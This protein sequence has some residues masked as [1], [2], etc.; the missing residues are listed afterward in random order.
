MHS[1][2]IESTL[3]KFNSVASLVLSILV[4]SRPLIAQELST[5]PSSLEFNQNNTGS[6]F[7]TSQLASQSVNGLQV[8]NTDHIVLQGESIELGN[9][10]QGR[11]S[12]RVV[13]RG[14]HLIMQFDG[15]LGR[16]ERKRLK[17]DGITVL[18][19]VSENNYWVCVDKNVDIASVRHVRWAA[20]PAAR[21]KMDKLVERSRFPAYAKYK[22]DAFGVRVLLFEGADANKTA[23]VIA[24]FNGVESVRTD[25]SNALSVR[26]S[27]LQMENIAGL[28][29]VKWLEPEAPP[30]IPFNAIAAER[31][32]AAALKASPYQLLGTG[33]S[34]GVWDGG[35]VDSH[36]DFGGRLTVVD[37]VGLNGHATHVAGTLAGSGAGYANAEGMAPEV[38]IY[39]YDW[40]DDD[41]EMRNAK[42]NRQ[43][44]I[45]NHSYGFSTGWNENQDGTWTDLGSSGFGRYDS[46]AAS[47]DDIVYDTGLHIFKA[48]GNERAHGPDCPAGP[49][50]DGPYDSIPYRG[51]AK[52]IYT[53][54]GTDDSDAMT[55]FS[56]W[57]PSNDGRIKPDLCANGAT[58]LS[59]YTGGQYA[60]S[61]GSSFASPSAA[62]T[63]ALLL[64]HFFASYSTEPSVA[65]LKTLMI[66]GAKD[67]GSDG[68][69]YQFGWGLIDAEKTAVLIDNKAFAQGLIASQSEIQQFQFNY[70]GGDLKVSLGWVDPA[71]STVASK[72]LVNDLDLELVAPGGAVYKPWVLNKDK[73][74]QAASTGTNN[75]DNTEQVLVSSA[76]AGSWTARVSASALP[77]GPQA[78]ALTG[79]GISPVNS[80]V[81]VVSN[82][83]E[84]N[85]NVSSIAPVTPAPWMSITP[86]GFS[87]SAGGSQIV[88]VLIDFTLAQEGT[89]STNLTISSNAGTDSFSV[90]VITPLSDTD[91][92]GLSDDIELLLGTKLNNTDSDDDGLSDYDEVN[93]DGDPSNYTIG[94]DLDPNDEDTDGDGIADGDDSEPLVATKFA[95]VPMLPTWAIF[96]VFFAVFVIHRK[97]QK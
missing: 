90:Q 9:L 72:A 29:N 53:I 18:S 46:Y 5:A 45:S 80:K 31:V 64:E 69:D 71:G 85:L 92:D 84:T 35:D 13:N 36:N 38:K 79:A 62:G 63:A 70:A 83:G 60:Q 52:N 42:I 14:R 61:S 95:V 12:D 28:E 27:L 94:I 91:G 49:D 20:K 21:H 41:S 1:R 55:S 4:L 68:P 26:G 16:G 51:N 59:T 93:R 24:G 7:S 30:V 32:K 54:C 39:S 40:N 10:L 48:A 11:R 25:G 44:L 73:P 76:A 88:R 2:L 81:F 82:K 22:Q 89:S 77:E 75:L 33:I 3:Q 65:L 67:L 47:Y 43:I 97:W 6:T 96:S 56:S 23:D 57:G 19:Y 37:N 78:F 34:A 86:T 87:L 8:I 74:S 66:H 15:E 58:V 50:C 17:E